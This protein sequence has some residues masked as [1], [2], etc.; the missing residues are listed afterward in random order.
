MATEA[1]LGELIEQ[2]NAQLGDVT[3]YKLAVVS[4]RDVEHVEKNAHYMT[5]QMYRKMVDNV[6]HDGNLSSLPFCWRDADGRFIALSGNHRVDVARDAQVE[7]ILVLYTD[8]ELSRSEQVAIQLSH[9][10][11]VGEDNPAVLRD[12]WREINSAALKIYSGLDEKVLNA[13]EPANVLRPKEAALR[14]EEL[15]ILFLPHEREHMDEIARLLTDRAKK[16]RVHHWLAPV[17]VFDRFF[18]ALL[19]FKESANIV[20]TGTAILA[21]LDIVET[22]L[23]EHHEAEHD[24]R[25]V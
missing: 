23:A 15:S 8:R 20:N 11:L 14:F 16:A 10:A 19:T 9:N 6:K 18:D 24:E 7:S 13:L 4:P 25:G 2:L 12:L 3:P 17:E 5:G 1:R 22:W 21:M